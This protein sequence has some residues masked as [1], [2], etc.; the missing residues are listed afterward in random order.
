M[1]GISKIKC[2]LGVELYEISDK[3]IYN[4]RTAQKHRQNVFDYLPKYVLN[5]NAGQHNQP[6][7]AEYHHQFVGL[8]SND[9]T[10]DYHLYFSLET[11]DYTLEEEISNV[12]IEDLFKK[13]DFLKLLAKFVPQS[14]DDL[15]K[16][17]FPRMNYLIVE[18]TYDVTYDHDGG[19]DCDMDIDISGYL[20]DKLE[21]TYFNQ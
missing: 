21:P 9:T 15:S 6:V 18:I 17:V 11:L 5:T 2:L 14:E 13:F 1:E 4:L 3:F 7:T 10:N 19:Y 12:G 20:N 16:F 8:F